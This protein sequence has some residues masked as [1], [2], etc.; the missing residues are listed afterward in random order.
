MSGALSGLVGMVR[1][2]L[3]T[4]ITVG[5]D[6]GTTFGY[7]SGVFGSIAA[8]TF[9]DN[10]ATTRTV[11]GVTNNHST[12]TLVLELVGT[13]IPNTAASFSSISVEGGAFYRTD[14]T[15]L[16]DTGGGNTRWSWSTASDP[17]PTSGS[18]AFLVGV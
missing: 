15:Y 5:D 17:M 2:A 7:F 16:A 12:D 4:T 18:A 1:Q 10:T 14:A 13:D 11:G 6:G 8:E 9:V 3:S